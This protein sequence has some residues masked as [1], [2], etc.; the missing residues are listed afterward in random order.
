MAGTAQQGSP[1]DGGARA[2]SSRHNGQHLKKADEQSRFIAKLLKAPDS[3]RF[4]AV[5]VLNNNKGDS[6]DD[7]SG[8]EACGRRYH[9]L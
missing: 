5:P 1:E 4:S 2:G 9:Y 8:K 3:G 6:V 7:R